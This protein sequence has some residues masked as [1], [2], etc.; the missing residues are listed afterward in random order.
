MSPFRR[1]RP[2]SFK[3][4]VRPTRRTRAR[5]R[6]CVLVLLQRPPRPPRRSTVWRSRYG[7]V[8]RRR[9][10]REPIPRVTSCVGRLRGGSVRQSDAHRPA[11]SSVDRRHANAQRDDAIP[12][13]TL[14]LPLIY[15]CTRTRP[16][17]RE[18]GATLGTPCE[19]R[20]VDDFQ[21]SA[22]PHHRDYAGSGSG[23]RLELR[24][25]DV[26]S[27]RLHVYA[28]HRTHST[29]VGAGRRVPAAACLLLLPAGQLADR[30][31]RTLIAA[32]SSFRKPSSWG[33]S[34]GDPLRRAQLWRTP[35]W[36]PCRAA[37]AIAHR[38]AAR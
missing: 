29:S 32:D 11:T 5:E 13:V 10:F 19:V 23:S 22:G 6:D 21:P 33:C 8:A 12:V 30:C 31:L 37:S 2:R 25:P 7:H 9:A 20:L 18:P 3:A 16:K 15:F 36:P 4:S 1:R 35:P 38:P 24:Y 28:I 17:P 14:P 27:H 34:P 26:S